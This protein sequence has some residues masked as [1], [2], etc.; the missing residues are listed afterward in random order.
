MVK[1]LRALPLLLLLTACRKKPDV[2]L[3]VLSGATTIVAPG[4][5][6]IPD[7][8]IVIAGTKIRSVGMRKDIPVTGAADRTDFGGEWIVPA[9][10]ARIAVDETA[11]LIILK[12]PP[13]GVTPANPSDISARIDAGEWQV[14]KTNNRP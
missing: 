3:K 10:G 6:A 12:H 8:I 4:A 14:P 7:S 2:R 1:L 9:E 11:N 5:Q 13:N